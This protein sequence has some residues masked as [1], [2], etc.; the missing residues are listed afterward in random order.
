[1]TP[2]RTCFTRIAGAY[3]TAE[4]EIDNTFNVNFLNLSGGDKAKN[5]KLAKTVPFART[6]EQLR[7][8]RFP[9]EAG[10]GSGFWRLLRGIHSCGLKNDLLMEALYEQIGLSYVSPSDYAVA[11][12]HGVYDVPMKASD[13][14][15]LYESEE[16]YDF[17]ICTVSPTLPDYEIGRPDFGFLFPAF[18][19]RSGDEGAIDLYTRA[20]ETAQPALVRRILG[21]G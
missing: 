16:V 5:L 20:P 17:I 8:R 14:G 10:K 2:T 4:G 21:G 13:K 15:Y 6:N 18:S 7:E 9:E 3:M 12:F 19:F 1:M 11:V